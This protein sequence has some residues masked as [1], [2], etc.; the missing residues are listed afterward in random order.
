MPRVV[1]QHKMDSMVFL[2][3]FCFVLLC[4]GILSFWFFACLFCRD[5]VVVVVVTFFFLKERMRP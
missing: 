3:T 5:I 4:L 2:W 1:G